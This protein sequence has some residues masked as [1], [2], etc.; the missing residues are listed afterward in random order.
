M[1]KYVM[2]HFKNSCDL[3]KTWFVVVGKF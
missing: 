1:Q 2:A 3:S